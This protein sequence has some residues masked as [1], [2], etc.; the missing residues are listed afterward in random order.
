MATV[1][2]SS[3]IDKFCFSSESLFLQVLRFFG[4]FVVKTQ[5]RTYCRISSFRY[6]KCKGA[7][8]REG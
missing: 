2:D 4:K 1:L 6:E 8:I 5:Q 3:L 7:E